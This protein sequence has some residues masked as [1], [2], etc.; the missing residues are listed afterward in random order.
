MKN[1]R[2]IPSNNHLEYLEPYLRD[3]NNLSETIPND[4]SKT[5]RKINNPVNLATRRNRFI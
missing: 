5:E 3:K 2:P 1:P 4:G